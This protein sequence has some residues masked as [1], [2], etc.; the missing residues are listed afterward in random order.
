M[1][2]AGKKPVVASFV[3]LVRYLPVRTEENESA[4]HDSQP[5]A[6]DMISAPHKYQARAPPTHMPCSVLILFY[7]QAMFWAT[8]REEYGCE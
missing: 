6:R 1:E 8:A 7:M 5:L 3:E 2:R 4:C